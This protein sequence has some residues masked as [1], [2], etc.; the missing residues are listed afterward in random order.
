MSEAYFPIFIDL[1]GKKIVIV[2]GGRIAARRAGVLSEFADDITVI[3]PEAADSIREM[4]EAGSVRWIREKY[5]RE[6]ILDADIVLACT[7]SEEVN[8]DIVAAC[9]CL[10]ILVNDCGRRERC[11]FYFPGVVKRG[12]VVVGVTASG[13]DHSQARAVRE[14]IERTLGDTE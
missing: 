11:D 10:G 2:G 3:A 7:D 1:S 5:R 8:G 6:Q 14:K 13:T 12:N 9:R 4:S